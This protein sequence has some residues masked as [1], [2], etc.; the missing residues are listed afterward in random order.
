MGGVDLQI[1]AGEVVA[2]EGPSGSGKTTLLQL[3]DGATL[4]VATHDAELAARAPR[5]LAMRDGRLAGSP[6]GS[7]GLAVAAS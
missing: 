5:R 7:G 1:E 6:A 3:L 4:V 2:L